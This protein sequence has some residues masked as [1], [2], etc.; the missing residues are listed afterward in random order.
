MEHLL[1]EV[2]AL[3]RETHWHFLG[4]DRLLGKFIDPER[5]LPYTFIFRKDWQQLTL[6]F[7]D[8]CL[9]DQDCIHTIRDNAF[10]NDD[11]AA[12]VDFLLELFADVGHSQTIVLFE[13]GQFDL[14]ENSEVELLF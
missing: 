13:E 1:Y 9:A 6:I 11:L 10:A 3:Q 7:E 14:Q 8:P 4:H 12:I 2:N 5:T